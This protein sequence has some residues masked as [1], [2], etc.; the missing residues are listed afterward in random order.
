MTDNATQPGTGNQTAKAFVDFMKA[1]NAPGAV[2]AKTKKFLAIALSISQKCDPCLKLHIEGALSQGITWDEIDEIAWI[3]I[4]FTGA[5]AKMFYEE[6]K[7]ELKA[8]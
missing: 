1:T 6:I 7:R 4:S 8:K 2:D 5:P 3:A